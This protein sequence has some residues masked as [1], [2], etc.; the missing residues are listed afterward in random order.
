MATL[1]GIVG[2]ILAPTPQL[3]TLPVTVAVLGVATAA[4]P[5]AALRRRFGCRVVF[6][7]GLAWASAGALL[8]AWSIEVESFLG[9]C[10]GCFIMGN[11]MAFMAQYRF[12]AAE[13]VEP[14]RV[15]RAI[16]GVMLGM[17]AAAVFAP[18]FALEYRDLFDAEFAG[19][20]AVL[21][22][23]Y[24]LAAVLIATLSLPG[25]DG[26]RPEQ[27]APVKV[28]VVLASRTVQLAIIA[29]AAGYGVMSLIMTATPISMHV[30]DT[31]SVEATAGVIRAH[32]LAMFTPSL[33][34]GLLIQ[35]LGIRRMLWLG[36][37]L[38]LACIGIALTGHG[39]WQYRLALVALGCGWNFLFVAGTTLLT[40]SCSR[41]QSIRVQGIN[42]LTMFG[43]MAVASLSAGGL[44]HQFGWEST[45]LV[46]VGLLALI[47][48]ALLRGRSGA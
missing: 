33:F 44:L 30:M 28:A 24:G 15:G 14:N 3:A 27:H 25:P 32:V 23:T 9:Y 37:L 35:K 48:I 36:V 21:L 31:H 20:F 18:W 12:A 39:V 34:S 38:E 19:S 6:V 7:G 42:D 22:M 41:E 17:L 40:T 5:A 10:L 45:N 4:W 46:A 13:L 1:A 47:V 11:N 29:A 26:P 8:A 16:S 43:T 2:A